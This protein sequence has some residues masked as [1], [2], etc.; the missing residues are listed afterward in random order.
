MEP[1][2]TLVILGERN[3]YGVYH[4]GRLINQ[5]AGM[6]L[7]QIESLL[8]E[9][10]PNDLD[11]IYIDTCAYWKERGELPESFSDLLYYSEF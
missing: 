11:H 9:L 7:D 5:G 1:N 2:I 10:F 8:G 4:S 6:Y 3:W